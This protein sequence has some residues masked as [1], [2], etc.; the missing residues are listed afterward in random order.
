[1]RI[2]TRSDQQ[3]R[4]KVRQL[5]EADLLVVDANPLTQ[6]VLR[7]ALT[8]HTAG[9]AFVA[10]LLQAI[11]YLKERGADHVLAD[12]TALGL[13]MDAVWRLAEAAHEAG[14]LFTL[15]WPAPSSAQVEEFAARNVI[16]LEKP[17]SVAELLP[18]L[19]NRYGASVADTGMAA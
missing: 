2:Q 19:R 18:A 8:A 7:A 4:A 6:G 3:A 9:L 12:G 14:S 10:N 17:I 13:E 1:V 11:L 15:L 5:A 16:I